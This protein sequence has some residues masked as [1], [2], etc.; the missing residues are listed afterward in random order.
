MLRKENSWP[1]APEYF[2]FIVDYNRPLEEMI[3]SGHYD[4]K[5]GEITAKRFPVR[6]EKSR[7]EFVARYFHFDGTISSEGAINEMMRPDWDPAKI[8]HLLSHG[9]AFPDE[10][11]KF[12]IVGLG[13]V[14]R[15]NSGHHLAPYLGVGVSGR[16]L[17]LERFYLRE[18]HPIVRFLAVR[19]IKS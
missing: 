6:R 9:A 11:T 8:E 12:P 4:R 7:R 15:M 3:V 10:Q 2:R 5:N 14:A 19:W 17:E 1:G 16:Q 13:S 18:W